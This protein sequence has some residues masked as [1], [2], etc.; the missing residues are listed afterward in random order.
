[1]LNYHHTGSAQ[2][3]HNG[4]PIWGAFKKA[5]FD[6]LNRGIQSWSKAQDGYVQLKRRLEFRHTLNTTL[7][8]SQRL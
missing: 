5:A 2:Q 7:F 1:M 8:Q 4:L 6:E 3:V